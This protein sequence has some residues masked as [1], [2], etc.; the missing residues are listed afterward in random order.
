MS[1]LKNIT[2]HIEKK[3]VSVLKVSEYNPRKRTQK[4]KE[5]LEQSIK[6]FGTV[7]PGVINI[8]KRKNILI[9]GHGRMEIY[10]EK[11][12]DKMDVMVPSRPLTLK[13]EKELNLRLN[14]NVGSWD[15]QKLG[16]I[17][18]GLLLEVGFGEDELSY[19]FDDVDVIDDDY[20]VAKE[21]KSIKKPTIHT[22]EI[23]QLGDHRLM[24]GDNSEPEDVN[25]LMNGKLADMIFCDP[26]KNNIDYIKEMDITITNA[27]AY[28]KPNVH[29]FYWC[30][31]RKIN[32]VQE[33]Y[34]QHGV[35]NKN[36]VI[37]VKNDITIVPKNAFNKAYE[38]CIYGT[39]GNPYLNENITNLNGIMNKEVGVGNAT[40]ADV[41]DILTIWIAKKD[42]DYL[43]NLEKPITL[44]EK[45]L[46]RCTGAMN[47]VLD[48]YGGSG[49]T[50]MACTQLVRKCFIMEEDP[51]LASVI[52]D[53]WEKFTNKK[54]ERL[55]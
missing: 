6:Q 17:D 28:S 30:D 48:L 25:K 47:I 49:N 52:M 10:K 1:N 24:C 29:I 41:M 19:L 9:G 31:E 14:K 34:E 51:I 21:L 43:Y 23:W 40:H 15:Q 55:N 45:P 54:A 37:W 20:N 39:R 7:E 3:S 2:W 42:T 4:E 46:K 35:K 22:G 12:I 53:R 8:G 33:L 36:V 32:V 13:E 27:L 26:P 11:G 18:T 50:L 5:D 16:D 44:I 38:P